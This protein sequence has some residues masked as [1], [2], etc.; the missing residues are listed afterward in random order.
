LVN[1]RVNLQKNNLR[2][3]WKIW[4][5]KDEIAVKWKINV[6]YS[7]YSTVYTLRFE[8]G[9]ALQTQSTPRLYFCSLCLKYGLFLVWQFQPKRIVVVVVTF[10]KK[11]SWLTGIVAKSVSIDCSLTHVKHQQ[12]AWQIQPN[13]FDCASQKEN[14]LQ[15]TENK[16]IIEVLTSLG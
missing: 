11:I 15:N 13:A 6:K 12:C 4:K 10:E 9:L 14:T 3:T 1:P 8:L 7:Q 5:W 16:R 2:L